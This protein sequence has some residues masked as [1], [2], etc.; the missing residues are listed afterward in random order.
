MNFAQ[1]PVTWLIIWIKLSGFAVYVGLSIHKATNHLFYQQCYAMHD[2]CRATCKKRKKHLLAPCLEI[3]HSFHWTLLEIAFITE[4]MIESSKSGKSIGCSVAI[5]NRLE[6]SRHWW[7]L[8]PFLCGGLCAVAMHVN[9]AWSQIDFLSNPNTYWLP[10]LQAGRH[11]SLVVIGCAWR[12]IEEMGNHLPHL[13]MLCYSCLGTPQSRP[14]C[15]LLA[16]DIRT[17]C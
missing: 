10:G 16:L 3:S 4:T 14:L 5:N 11:F 8:R 17:S 15:L 12:A 2:L 7:N 13:A 9:N 6:T 1:K